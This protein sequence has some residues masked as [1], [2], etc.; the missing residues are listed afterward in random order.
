MNKLTALTLLASAVLL[1]GCASAPEAQE[2]ASLLKP[3]YGV[4][5]AT[6]QFTVKG[7]SEDARQH[8][9]ELPHIAAEIVPV[10]PAG[11]DTAVLSTSRKWR[12]PGATLVTPEGDRVMDVAALKPGRYKIRRLA[13]S[14]N[15]L[16]KQTSVLPTPD[17]LFDVKEGEVTYMGSIQ[18][19]T[20][21]GRDGQGQQTPTAITLAVRD[22]FSADTAAM[23]QADPGMGALVL[24]DG[25]R[26]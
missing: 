21:I 9:I 3:G 13:A 7:T 16:N 23:K 14:F 24:R 26:P 17:I 2:S 11:G 25:L 12:K 8:G 6:L 5:A 22:E 4:V 10:N 20:T 1:A 15:F 18:A 19:I